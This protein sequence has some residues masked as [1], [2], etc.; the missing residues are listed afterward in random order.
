MY[1]PVTDMD[2]IIFAI[3]HHLDNLDITYPLLLN[4]VFI[5]DTLDDGNLCT[6]CRFKGNFISFLFLYFH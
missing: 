2:E 6:F 1:T 4:P 5:M 3:N